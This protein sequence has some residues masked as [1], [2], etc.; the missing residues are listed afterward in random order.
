MH[1]LQDN[2]SFI[3]DVKV[4]ALPDNGGLKVTLY[5]SDGNQIPKENLSQGEK[6]LYISSL[7]KAILQEAIQDFPI[8]IDTPLGRLD[9][10]HIN[11]MLLSYY[12]YLAKQ[13]VILATNNEI[14]P[15]RYKLIENEVANAYL[16]IN[17]E[18]KTIVQ[19]GYFQGYEN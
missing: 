18:N 19:S 11:N 3:A 16:L 2:E 9:H 1:K 6:Q 5:N 8:F 17:K 15:S 4:H 13:V 10:E 12:P 14:P 7:L